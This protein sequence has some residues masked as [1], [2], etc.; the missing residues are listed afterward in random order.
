VEYNVSRSVSLVAV[1]DQFGIVSFD[2][3]VRQRKR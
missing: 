3:R 2:V 1:R